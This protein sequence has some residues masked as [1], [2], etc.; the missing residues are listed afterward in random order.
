MNLVEISETLK[1]APDDF[2]VK[3]VQ[4]PDGTIPQF[5]ALSELQRRK[6]MRERFAT[7]QGPQSTVADDL[8]GGQGIAASAEPQT[9]PAPQAGP[10]AGIQGYR[11]GGYIDRVAGFESGNNPNAKNPYSSASGLYQ[12][13]DST[14]ASLDKRYGFDPRDRSAATERARMEAYT[15]ETASALRKRNLPVSGGTLYGGHLLGQA[16]VTNFLN[17]YLKNP[18]AKPSSVFSAE[19]IKKNPAIFGKA[20][21]L[22]DVMKKFD[23]VGGEG[24]PSGIKDRKDIAGRRVSD[25]NMSGILSLLS[26]EYE[27]V[28]NSSAFD[29]IKGLLSGS[30][31]NPSDI[32]AE[33]HAA[34]LKSLGVPGYAN[35]GSVTPPAGTSLLTPKTVVKD[36]RRFRYVEQTGQWKDAS[37]STLNPDGTITSSSSTPA[38]VG[39]DPAAAGGDFFSSAWSRLTNR[40][41]PFWKKHRGEEVPPPTTSGPGGVIPAVRGL[42]GAMGPAF[43]PMG[44]MASTLAAPGVADFGIK[45]I[46]ELATKAREMM[47]TPAPEGGVSPSSEPDVAAASPIDNVINDFLNEYNSSKMSKDDMKQMALLQA[48]FG[49]MAGDSPWAMV[50]VGRGGLAGIAAYQ[51]AKKNNAQMAESALNNALKIKAFEGAQEDRQF[52][53]EYKT[54]L[55]NINRARANAYIESM[56][57]RVGQGGDKMMTKEQYDTYQDLIGRLIQAKT[58]MGQEVTYNDIMQAADLARAGATAYGAMPSASSGTREYDVAHNPEE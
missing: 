7:P 35:Q 8:T 51:D 4:N 3:H 17:A 50:N 15:N 19:V 26:D 18:D 58:E 9:S 10:E 56:A 41:D 6:D 31:K 1:G 34:V 48:G 27:P 42:I 47:P 40:D 49:M 23:E 54:E 5:M 21:T 37:G 32:G 55:L 29:A 45:K 25:K 38:D 22:E 52:E 30:Q 57:A 36:G 20:R 33:Q 53:R 11:Y 12:L 46:M 43:G 28:D 14:R 2:L 16:G 39:G 44:V 24:I 13:I